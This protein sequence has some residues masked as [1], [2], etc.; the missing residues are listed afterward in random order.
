MG[1]IDLAVVER[2]NDGAV[3]HRL[4][5]MR[6]GLQVLDHGELSDASDHGLMCG[7][8]LIDVGQL[9]GFREHPHSSTFDYATE[10]IGRPRQLCARSHKLYARARMDLQ[11][12]VGFQ[13]PK[14][15]SQGPHGAAGD[16]Y[17]VTL[18]NE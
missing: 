16:T 8:N 1:G 13:D 17:Q 6:P 3:K 12:A 14:R 18:R 7:G 4:K 11:H 2:A 15:I 10:L 5:L 9:R